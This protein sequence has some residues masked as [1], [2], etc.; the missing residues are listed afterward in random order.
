MLR[1]FKDGFLAW[2]AFHLAQRRLYILS[3]FLQQEKSPNT[4][5]SQE[6]EQANRER[7]IVQKA[8]SRLSSKSKACT[9]CMGRCCSGDHNLF[10]AVDFA[11]RK[12]SN[13]PLTCYGYIPESN[14]LL[15]NYSWLK[16]DFS[17]FLSSSNIAE[18]QFYANRKCDK[19][20]DW[21]CS[22][23]PEDR[24]IICLTFTCKEFRDGLSNDDLTE[25]A[26]L[27]MKVQSIQYS[28]LH[29]LDRKNAVYAKLR[30]ALVF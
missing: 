1:N 19:L 8:I 3:W 12:N 24:P 15:S 6:I 23:P 28:T 17:Y 20:T 14:E 18:S 29:L 10:T 22:L 27:T 2:R 21:G 5:Y 25:L 9:Q 16:R 13:K 4:F 11:L 7:M 30:C 26:G